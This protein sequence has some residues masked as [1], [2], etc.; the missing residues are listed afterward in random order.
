[1]EENLPLQQDN[2]A[3]ED[4]RTGPPLG[5]NTVSFYGTFSLKVKF[6][7]SGS[8]FSLFLLRKEE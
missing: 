6:L 2:L 5:G 7:I 8:S 3:Q 1:M 4:T